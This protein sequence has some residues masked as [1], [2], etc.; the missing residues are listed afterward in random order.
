MV[1]IISD[2]LGIIGFIFSLLSF[3]FIHLTNRKFKKNYENHK[4]RNQSKEDLLRSIR[5]IYELMYKDDFFDWDAL[6]DV[7]GN[8]SR[9][10]N[11]TY[12]TKRI[13]KS[14]RKKLLKITRKP[15]DPYLE[16]KKN[17]IMSELKELEH[18]ISQEADEI[19]SLFS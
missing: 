7:G 9:Y 10:K 13:N 3:L 14:L 16:R 8:I 6:N 17:K 5:G 18:R 1:A 19:L 11:L 12:K 2:W 4:F 15:D